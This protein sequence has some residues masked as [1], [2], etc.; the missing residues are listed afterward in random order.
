MR[1][2]MLDATVIGVSPK[3]VYAGVVQFERYAE[4]APHVRSTRGARRAGRRRPGSPAGSCTS[5]A[6]VELDRAERFLLDEL[7]I[8]FEQD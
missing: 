4:L 8:E 1:T 7:I 2:C 5:A 6:A 3:E